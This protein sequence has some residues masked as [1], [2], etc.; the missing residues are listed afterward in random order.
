MPT[1]KVQAPDGSILNIDGPADATDSELQQIAAQ[2]WTPK[3]PAGILETVGANVAGGLGSQLLGAGAAATDYAGLPSAAK[4]LDEKRKAVEEF[5]QSHGGD[6]TLGRISSGVG[7]LAPA[8][9][10]PEAGILELAANAGLFALPGFRDTYKAQ[11]EAGA[12]P[13]VAAEHAVADAGLMMVGGRLVSAGGKALPKS[14]QAGERLAP[15]VAQAAGE[16]AVF[17]AGNSAINKGIDVANQNFTNDKT[18]PGS[19][20]APWVDPRAMAESAASFGA[21]RGI[22]R[23]I[24][25]K[26][27]PTT[28][29]PPATPPADTTAPPPVTPAAPAA[30]ATADYATLFEARDR[31]QRAPKSPENDAKIAELTQQMETAAEEPSPT[32][33]P[34][35][36]PTKRVKTAPV[37]AAQPAEVTPPAD[38]SGLNIPKDMAPGA[39]EAPPAAPTNTGPTAATVITANDIS[40]MADNGGK[41]LSKANQKWLTENLLGK[42]FSDVV[43]L[44]NSKPELLERRGVGDVLASIFHMVHLENLHANT[45]PAKLQP[46]T[47]AGG[48]ERGV[49]VSVQPTETVGTKEEAPTAA[50]APEKPSGQRLVPA[51]QPTT[52]RDAL[53]RAQLNPLAELPPLPEPPVHPNE[54]PRIKA[55]VSEVPAAPA[56]PVE[57]KTPPT[58][59]TSKVTAETPEQVIARQQ[60]AEAVK[61]KLAEQAAASAQAKTEPTNRKVVPVRGERQS[62]HSFVDEAKAEAERQIAAEKQGT[63]VTDVSQYVGYEPREKSAF[64]LAK[65]KYDEL[66]PV[67][68]HVL[69]E[70]AANAQRMKEASDKR[71][72]EAARAKN[73]TEAAKAT[74]SELTDISKTKAKAQAK[75][76]KQ[77][78]QAAETAEPGQ[79]AKRRAG[80]VDVVSKSREIIGALQEI[81]KGKFPEGTKKDAQKHLEEILR[82]AKAGEHPESSLEPAFHFLVEQASKPR[83]ARTLEKVLPSIGREKVQSVVDTLK[84]RWKNAPD[85]V[86]VDN[87]KNP[88]VPEALRKADAE[89]RA[90]GAEGDPAGVFHDG[91]VYLFADH[92]TS[93]EHALRTMLHESLG[94]YGLRGVFGNDLNPI[95]DQVLKDHHA[96]IDEIAKKYGLDMT[97]PH[98]AQEAAEEFLANLAQT[99]PTMGIVQRLIAAVRNGLR[100]MGMDVKM[101]N[102]DLIANY[103][104][105]ARKFVENSRIDRAVNGE[106]RFSRNGAPDPTDQIF[107][108]MGREAPKEDTRSYAEKIKDTLAPAADALK[109]K[110]G[111]GPIGRIVDAAIDMLDAGAP[112]MRSIEREVRATLPETEANRMLTAISYSQTSH[113]VGV[114]TAAIDAGG[115]KYDPTTHKFKTEDSKYN[116]KALNAVYK[117]IIDRTG[118][119]L[120]EVRAKVSAAL[121]SKRMLALFDMQDRMLAE[122]NT[123][124]TA[125]KTRAAKSLREKADSYIFHMT[126][127]Q[128]TKGMELYKAWPEIQKID[129]IKEGMRKWVRSLMEDSGV[130]SPE[131]G[132]WMLDNAEWI[133]FQREMEN[134]DT[135][136]GF[137]SYV[138]GLQV[139][140]R[141]PGFK[142]SLKDVHDV[143]DNFEKWTLYSVSRSIKNQKSAD[144]AKASLQYLPPTEAKAVMYVNPKAANRTVSYLEKGN[145][146]YVEFDSAAKAEIFKG[147]P[148]MAYAALPYV[149]GFVDGFNKIFRTS[150]VNSPLFPAM[151]LSMDAM[152]AIYISGLKP[153]YAF[154]IPYKAVT[155]T[156]KTLRG[157]SEAHKELKRF[158]AVGVHDY[159]ATLS[160]ANAEVEAGLKREN[161]WEKYKGMMHNINLATD[162]GVR[163]AVYLAARESGL[164]EHIAVEKAFEII[165]FRT[166][167]GNAGLAASARHVVFMNSFYAASRVTLN[168]L[169]KGD[170]APAERAKAQKTLLSNLAWIGGISAINAMMN[171]GDE[172]YEKLS[173]QQQA[174]RL[175]LPGL[176]GWGIPLRPDAF[177]LV[178]MFAEQAVRQSTDEY[179]DDPAKL[180]TVLTDALVNNL[181]GGSIPVELP[182]KLAVE[183]E[184]NYNFFEERPIVGPGLEKLEGWRQYSPETSEFAKGVGATSKD[185]AK[186]VGS[187]YTGLSPMKVD[188]FIR[189]TLGSF[190][191]MF[192]LGTNSL[193]GN[194]PSRSWQD[195]I[196]TFPGLS[197]VGVREF[198]NETATD[199][200]D[201]AEHVDEAVTTANKLQATGQF[202]DYQKYMDE[203]RQ[204]I[205]YEGYVKNIENTLGILRNQINRIAESDLPPDEKESRIREVQI[206]Q[207]RMMQNQEQYL[208]K[209][210]TEALVRPTGIL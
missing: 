68:Q 90:K 31:A 46:T 69:N 6:T 151:Q 162:N 141:E 128:A 107:K 20:N 13:T 125:G 39:M 79:E 120:S 49:G 159:N 210:R 176:H 111:V 114:G 161:L 84:S 12:S 95:L 104:L 61:A 136:S 140:A 62:W 165:N 97:D 19:E 96:A 134:D 175:T 59:E 34:I 150:V 155:E 10:M 56:A 189:G 3:K 26:P 70:R 99:R 50:G 158:G 72:A 11:T 203:N 63:G 8:L 170:I 132:Q 116:R 86:V 182:E 18:A 55:P 40:T 48:R 92:I 94:H 119:P 24:H 169:R 180:R 73:E 166:R 153:K 190:G 5:Q 82:A 98:D 76:A 89:A 144:L 47:G 109:P 53:K 149:N 41:P 206:R 209:I 33:A 112:L 71:A 157:T 58:A 156:I 28:E 127:D 143:M 15:Q 122:A 191:G 43:D 80:A 57:P 198:A 101:S 131:Y 105:P 29:Q 137:T 154:S 1:F 83:F 192:L 138:R 4:Y 67:T 36:E 45:E 204:K 187:T 194:R 17:T 178:K 65:Q 115:L 7:G 66:S 152:S 146:K 168:L 147:N 207:Q 160:R 103:I 199:F 184:G 130:W 23:A 21:L 75:E 22:H 205:R 118:K 177:L 91:K 38:T 174:S 27:A 135:A 179:A 42:T 108:D 77:E 196:A 87:I 123:L 85:V 200:H 185:L 60:E 188:H 44:V 93:P 102:N 197:R 30:P 9:L 88:S 195:T 208:K 51:E 35:P 74:E 113:D 100:R 133:P 171:T 173:R 110:D 54:T 106:T 201:L 186:A 181:I 183:L 202:N 81:I 126:R 139:K 2:S 78:Q 148:A 121:E 124:E 32:A 14:L 163:Q 142:G 167:V 52:T 129:D 193:F 25:G 37:K 145:L 164:P 172:D 16:G 64:E 117:E